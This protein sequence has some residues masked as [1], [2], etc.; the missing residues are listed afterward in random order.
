MSKFS[1]ICE[2]DQ[3]YAEAKDEDGAYDKLVGTFGDV[4]RELVTIREVDEIPIGS[5]EI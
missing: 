5:D 1:I 2:G 4:P 3:V